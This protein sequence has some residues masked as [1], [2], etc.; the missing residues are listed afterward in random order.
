M[1]VFSAKMFN[2]MTIALSAI[3]FL[4]IAVATISSIQ[5]ESRIALEF[6]QMLQ[7]VNDYNYNHLLENTTNN[8]IDDSTTS[9]AMFTNG[10]DAFLYGYY[11]YINS[12]TYY[13][14]SQGI[15][16]NTVAGIVTITTLSKNVMIKFA[17]GS[18]CYELITYE[19]GNT[20]GRTSAKQIYYDKLSNLVYMRDTKDVK[21]INNDLISSYT[22]PWEYDSVEYFVEEIGIIPGESIYNFSKKAIIDETYYKEVKVNGVIKEY[23]T[24]IVSNATLAGKPFARVANY[25]G[26]ATQMPVV[27]QMIENVIINA[28]GT[29]KVLV[30][31]DKY[32]LK[33]KVPVLGEKT[34]YCAS[35]STYRFITLGGELPV[36]QP[37]V[38]NAHPR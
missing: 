14:E 33:T 7:D 15:S 32:E 12:P 31:D 17:D 13:V 25:I 36:S 27:T 30:L 19:Q 9:E 8:D 35:K 20:Y 34:V 21:E 24:Q 3:F 4:S 28:D 29:L 5:E 16:T 37:D 18:A 23:Q 22:R 11:N 26:K 6:Q 2:M 10:T 38:S 1:R